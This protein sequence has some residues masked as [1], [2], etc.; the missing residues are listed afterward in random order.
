MEQP[1]EQQQQI[2]IEIDDITAQGI[3]SNLAIIS[4]SPDE[5]ILDFI[6][7]QPQIPKAKVRAR[8]ITSPQHIK[9]FLSAL[10]ENIKKYEEKFGEIK[11]EPKLELPKIGFVH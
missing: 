9:R 5:F 3:Y 2:Q 1:K 8:I 10:Q 6:F 11:T 7:I 4:H